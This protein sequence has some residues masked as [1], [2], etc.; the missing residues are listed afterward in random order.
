M[1]AI[2]LRCRP[3]STFR[4]GQKSLEDTHSYIHSD[5][6]FSAI[7]HTHALLHGKKKADELFHQFGEQKTFVLSSGYHALEI[8]K[9]KAKEGNTS[10][11]Q[12][13]Y[14]FFLPKPLEFNQVP[15]RILKATKKIH[16]ISK[17]IWEKGVK[18]AELTYYPCL[19]DRSGDP[20]SLYV[21]TWEELKKLKLISDSDLGKWKEVA[22]KLR[23]REISEKLNEQKED[24]VEDDTWKPFNTLKKNLLMNTS[25]TKTRINPKVQVRQIGQTAAYYTEKVLQMQALERRQE[26]LPKLQTHYYF[27]LQGFDPEKDLELKATLYLLGDEGIG[28]GRSTGNGLLEDTE[29][30]KFTFPQPSQPGKSFCMALSLPQSPD[31]FS[32]YRQ[33]Q[34][35]LR[36]GGSLAG[37]DEEDKRFY[38]K[39]VRMLSEGAT[40]ASS[41]PQVVGKYVEVSPPMAKHK[42]YRYGI[43]FTLP[44]YSS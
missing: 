36:G 19:G 43:S 22:I 30:R 8:P 25:L 38:R 31:E 24:C 11:E 34:L 17:G 40:L 10:D 37:D 12:R 20:D 35:V 16:F 27:L 32:H 44:I 3:H 1:Q 13:D 4:L 33:Y 28:G 6:I 5:T 42:R 23:K 14:L 18:A 39:Q 15:S 2:I 41:A 26:N 29:I 9:E 7:M 21:L